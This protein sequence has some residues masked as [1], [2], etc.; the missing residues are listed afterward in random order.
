VGRTGSEPDANNERKTM[1]KPAVYI[2]QETISDSL[3][4]QGNPS[5]FEDSIVSLL[6]GGYSV[7]LGNAEAPVRVFTEADEF[8]AWFNNLRVAIETA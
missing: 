7:G 5:I 2:S 4:K 8:S 1:N 3:T 6:N